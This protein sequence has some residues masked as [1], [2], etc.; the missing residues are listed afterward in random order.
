MQIRAATLEDKYHISIIHHEAFGDDE[1]EI[2][3]L[4]VGLL[5]S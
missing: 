4:M 1:G 5:A 2:I 3:I